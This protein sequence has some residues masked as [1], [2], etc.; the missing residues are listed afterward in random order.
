[1][2]RIII[3]SL[4]MILFPSCGSDN[5]QFI[6]DTAINI[7]VSDGEGNDLLNPV[8]V[9]SFMENEIKIFYIVNGQEIEVNNI[10]MAYP[11][12]FFIYED[13]NEF[14]LRV[15]P[16]VDKNSELPVTYIK[17]NDKVVDTIKCSIERK[18]NSEI[19]TKVWLND[20]LVWEGYETERFFEIIK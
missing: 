10:D 13:E 11:K 14:R 6:V 19:C 5:D 3:F 9:K 17:W 1:M 15:F 16:N 18:N 2:R 8:N 12:G 4:A 7:S 20:N